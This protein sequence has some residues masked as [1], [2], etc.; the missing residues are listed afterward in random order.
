MSCDICMRSLT[1]CLDLK[2]K[3]YRYSSECS[4]SLMCSLDNFTL[5]CSVS[6]FDRYWLFAHHRLSKEIVRG[7]DTSAGGEENNS[8]S[9][10]SEPVAEPEDEDAPFKF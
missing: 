9:H 7:V 8:A 4:F 5:T 6:F 10:N 1:E 3:K 2:S